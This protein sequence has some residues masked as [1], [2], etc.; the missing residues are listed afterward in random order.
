MRASPRVRSVT[1]AIALSLIRKGALLVIAVTVSV[2]AAVATAYALLPA[3]VEEQAAVLVRYFVS[4]ESVTISESGDAVLLIGS[5]KG[6]NAS[7]DAYVIFAT[8]EFL[9]TSISGTADCGRVGEPRVSIGPILSSLLGVERGDTV[10]VCVGA[11]CRAYPVACVNR[12][13]GVFRVSAVVI[14]NEAPAMGGWGLSLGESS[15]GYRAFVDGLSSFLTSFSFFVT[16]LVALAY[17]PIAYFGV[18]RVIQL[19]SETVSVLD[20]VGVP[21]AVVD[22]GLAT[23]VILLVAAAAFFGVGLGTVMSHFGA[24]VAGFFGLVISVRPLPTAWGAG[25]VIALFL[26]EGAAALIIAI[27]RGVIRWPAA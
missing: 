11:W 1:Y 27:R 5:V 20:A 17:L 26:G 3:A 23:S 15:T 12:G 25:L 14:D 7:A 19:S 8:E 24:W 10:E 9:R 21:R 6:G 18:R 16:V 2:P 22:R 4:K 13:G